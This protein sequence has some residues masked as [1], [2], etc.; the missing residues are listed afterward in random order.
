MAA[1]KGRSDGLRH[2]DK[3]SAHEKSKTLKVIIQ[4][5]VKHLNSN[6]INEP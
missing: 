5:Q 1:R 4:C 6:W 3:F 2:L